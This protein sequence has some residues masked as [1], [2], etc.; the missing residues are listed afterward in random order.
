ME[1]VT[2]DSG[3]RRADSIHSG[4]VTMFNGLLNASNW[5][6]KFLGEL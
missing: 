4:R 6:S 1:V 2:A 5:K 3:G